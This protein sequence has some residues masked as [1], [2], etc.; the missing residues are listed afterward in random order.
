MITP[1]RNAITPK[2]ISL[3]CYRYR[4][5]LVVC[6]CFSQLFS[7]ITLTRLQW[8][9]NGIMD[10]VLVFSPGTAQVWFIYV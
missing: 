6:V 8:D 4:Y 1:T 2:K 7:K 3:I 10:R 5:F 9:N